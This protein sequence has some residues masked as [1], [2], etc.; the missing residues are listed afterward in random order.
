M[1]KRKEGKEE[2]I[3]KGKGKCCYKHR[4]ERREKK[5]GKNSNDMKDGR[6]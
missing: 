1:R 4:K 2:T 3:N 5:G 6:N